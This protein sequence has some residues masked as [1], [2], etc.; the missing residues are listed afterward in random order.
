MALISLALFGN[1]YVYDAIGLIADL[2]QRQRGFTDT[3]IG[4][5][6]AI[7]SLPDVVPVLVRCRSAYP[8]GVCRK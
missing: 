8:L 2:F 7:Y 1:Y 3:R 4:M 6:N 5:L